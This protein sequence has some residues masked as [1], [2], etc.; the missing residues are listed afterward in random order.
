MV[1]KPA[2]SV[3]QDRGG[4]SA[5]DSSLSF[6]SFPGSRQQSH[7]STDLVPRVQKDGKFFSSSVPAHFST[8]RHHSRVHF[9]SRLRPPLDLSQ[10]VE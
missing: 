7:G 9:S 1:D 4:V 6:S 8:F 3:R 2:K 5:A 10:Q